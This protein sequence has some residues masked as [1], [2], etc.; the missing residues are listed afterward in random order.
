MASCSRS[1]GACNL[2]GPHAHLRVFDPNVS[3]SSFRKR[4]LDSS[5]IAAS[6]SR[7][8]SAGSLRSHR[9]SQQDVTDSR[10]GTPPDL[11]EIINLVSDSESDTASSFSHGITD[12][13]PDSEPEPDTDTLSNREVID[14]TLDTT[15]HSGPSA[16]RKKRDPLT[17]HF[18]MGGSFKVEKLK[19]NVD[20]TVC[21]RCYITLWLLSRSPD[22]EEAGSFSPWLDAPEREPGYRAAACPFPGEVGEGW[23]DYICEKDC[24]PLCARLKGTKACFEASLNWS[25]RRWEDCKKTQPDKG[26][27]YS[28]PLSIRPKHQERK[29]ETNVDSIFDPQSFRLAWSHHLATFIYPSKASEDSQILRKFD[30]WRLRIEQGNALPLEIPGYDTHFYSPL[31]ADD[32]K[33]CMALDGLEYGDPY[34]YPLDHSGSLCAFKVLKIWLEECLQ[35]HPMCA[36]ATHLRKPARLLDV[37]ASKDKGKTVKLISTAEAITEGERLRYTALSYCWGPEPH[38][39]TTKATFQ[40]RQNGIEIDDLPIVLADAVHITRTMNLQYVWI[41]AL[42]IIQDDFSDWETEAVKMGEIYAAAEFTISALSSANNRQGLLQPRKRDC[43]SV[44]TVRLPDSPNGPKETRLF[45]RHDPIEPDVEIYRGPLSSRSWTLQER[46]LSPAIVHYGRDQIIWECNHGGIK[47]ETTY[48]G[49]LDPLRQSLLKSAKSAEER[50]GPGKT[51][52]DRLQH[53]YHGSKPEDQV[54]LRGYWSHENEGEGDELDALD[55]E[56]DFA[57]RPSRSDRAPKISYAGAFGDLERLLGEP[58][59]V[60]EIYQY[61]V[62]HRIIE[63][64]SERHITKVDDRL[65]ALYGIAQRMNN[66]ELC[67]GP[68]AAGHWREDFPRGLLWV[69]GRDGYP[70]LTNEFPLDRKKARCLPSWSWMH[71]GL[72]IQHGITHPSESELKSCLR[73]GP[74]FLPS[75]ELPKSADDLVQ[76]LP[77]SQAQIRLTAFL[78]PVNR[79]TVEN[80][81]YYNTLTSRS[82]GWEENDLKGGGR[83]LWFMD[84]KTLYEGLESLPEDASVGR[85]DLCCVRIAQWQTATDSPDFNTAVYYLVLQNLG[86][87]FHDED[88]EPLDLYK[89]LGLLKLQDVKNTAIEQPWTEVYSKNGQRILGPGRWKEFLLI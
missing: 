83:A 88:D 2:K 45:F 86:N 15:P 8:K 81:A 51:V 30:Y 43:F 42:C 74:D 32:A 39:R 70:I 82:H 68:F 53:L 34:M 26:L 37:K 28:H 75:R 38:F 6:K 58:E 10:A 57:D 14:L 19:C 17:F 67:Q 27:P 25:R 21:H 54:G 31:L 1:D 71:C 73:T 69:T 80:A 36:R 35:D 18:A 23:N 4:A 61:A 3:S 59:K 79:K 89:R 44:G 63:E 11:R 65:P 76:K 78:Q 52:R 46:L 40:E 5:F 33:K 64:Y 85:Y 7:R 66:S 84:D 24:C 12:L 48:C 49:V 56:V 50:Q 29:N 77:I 47:S 20:D 22:E 55:S 62:W 13:M 41:D 9:N 60:E 87:E 72:P 16:Q